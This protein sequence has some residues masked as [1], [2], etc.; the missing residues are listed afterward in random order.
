MN[1]SGNPID[2]VFVFLGGVLLSFTPCVYPLIPITVG[3]LGVNATDSRLK[4]LIL[5]LLYVTGIAI[6]YSLLGLAA[7]LTGQIFGLISSHPLTNIIVGVAIILFS[8]SMFDMVY[9]SL[10]NIIKFPKHKKHDYLST[11]VLGLFSGLVIGP[12]LTPALA[13]ILTYLAVKKNILYGMIL[14]FC[15]AYGMGTVL[16]LIGAFS[17]ILSGL[18]KQG[19]WLLYIKK[20]GAV[21]ILAMGVYFIGVGIKR[22]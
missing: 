3:F 8:L 14:L 2:Y 6:T 22:L 12:C 21:I 11:F 20:I 16:I 17:N 9:I 19:K 1:L 18:P 10:P 4:G 5:S 13:T 15:F 7:S